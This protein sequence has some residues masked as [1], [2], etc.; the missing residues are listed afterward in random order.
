M[1]RLLFTL[2][3]AWCWAG[4]YAQDTIVK[5]DGTRTIA[6][7]K[8]IGQDE[9]R[10]KKYSNPD[11][12]VYVIER[13]AVRR[14][15]YSDG[16]VE[17]IFLFA[18]EA[19]IPGRSNYHHFVWTNLVGITMQKPSISY[20]LLMPGG[21]FSLVTTFST[22]SHNDKVDISRASWHY[23]LYRYYTAGIEA[24]Y[25][26]TGQSPATYFIGGS[27]AIGTVRYRERQDELP[28]F[29]DPVK[30]AFRSV[31]TLN[32]GVS[33][34]PHKQLSFSTSVGFGFCIDALDS[35]ILGIFQF[36]VSVNAGYRF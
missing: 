21:R 36:P 29:S 10:Y 19:F 28:V 22:G 32:N 26:P 18:P 31:V 23:N 13:K 12:P 16:L 20:Q 24:R 33:F 5:R 2:A 35:G 34:Y 3:A 1:S 25:Y 7:V 4:L 8:E 15:I 9:I 6:V 11:G 14:I 27:Y 30:K 17:E